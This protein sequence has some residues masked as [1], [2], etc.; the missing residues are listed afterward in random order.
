MKKKETGIFLT[1]VRILLAACG[2]VTA[3]VLL[4]AGSPDSLTRRFFPD[5]G[6]DVYLALA[7]SLAVFILGFFNYWGRDRAGFAEL[8]ELNADKIRLWRKKGKGDDEIA[9]SI[10]EALGLRKG[11]KYK[12][13][14]KKLTAY[15]AGFK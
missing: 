11:Y 8:I 10:L 9:A 13:A 3:Y 4:T 12:M 6:T 14:R 7:S 5:P 1:F 15:L 2:V